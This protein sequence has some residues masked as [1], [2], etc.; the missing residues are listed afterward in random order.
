[1]LFASNFAVLMEKYLGFNY[2]DVV[3]R[4]GKCA[5]DFSETESAK[6][7]THFLLTVF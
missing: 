2:K 3:Y 1:M 5:K 7:I 6:R 4:C